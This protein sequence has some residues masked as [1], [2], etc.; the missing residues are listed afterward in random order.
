M[1]E[2]LQSLKEMQLLV[3]G[4]VGHNGHPNAI[5]GNKL[6]GCDLTA[7][8]LPA[9]TDS[10]LST[11]AAQSTACN[12]DILQLLQVIHTLGSQSTSC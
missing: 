5:D 9:G 1:Q 7:A 4:I 6:S 8:N 2:H 12:V 10:C 3:N 11:T